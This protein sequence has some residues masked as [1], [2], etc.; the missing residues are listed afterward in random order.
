MLAALRALVQFDAERRWLDE[1]GEAGEGEARHV[2]AL[3]EA[4]G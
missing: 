4:L 3:T 2:Q 1:A